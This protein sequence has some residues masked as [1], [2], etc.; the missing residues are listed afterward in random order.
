MYCHHCSLLS[1]FSAF[2][3]LSR[4]ITFR[5]VI[6]LI[7][8]PNYLP[9]FLPSYLPTYLPTFQPTYLPTSLPTYLLTPTCLPTY[10]LT[11]LPTYLN[12]LPSTYLPIYLPVYLNIFRTKLERAQPCLYWELNPTRL[13]RTY[14]YYFSF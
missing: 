3:T 7:F 6:G 12:T 10:I 2:C 5:K 8:L 4:K 13:L 1:S 11:Y 9:T 14:T